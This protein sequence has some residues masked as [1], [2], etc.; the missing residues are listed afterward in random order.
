MCPFNAFRIQQ[1]VSCLCKRFNAW[2]IHISAT[3]INHIGLWNWG[4]VVRDGKKDEQ[5]KKKLVDWLEIILGSPF[6]WDWVHGAAA[7]AVAVTP[8]VTLQLHVWE[9][10]HSAW[11]FLTVC[12]RDVMWEA[13]FILAHSHHT[14]FVSDFF[15]LPHHSS[16]SIFELW[17]PGL[18][19]QSAW[20]PKFWSSP[21]L[22]S[23]SAQTIALPATT[24]HLLTFTSTLILLKKITVNNSRGSDG[25]LA[26]I[27]LKKNTL[28]VSSLVSWWKF[29]VKI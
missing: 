29:L 5:K 21:N 20:V 10:T 24:T 26:F 17:L 9:E 14:H 19:L 3:R 7:I 12:H 23:S 28:N 4:L 6:S 1:L 25:I 13:Y 22:L 18:V 15:H 2:I 8:A 16:G 27:E 11:F